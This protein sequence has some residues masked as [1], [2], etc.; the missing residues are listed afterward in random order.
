[1]KFAICNEVF[2]GWTID[3]SIKF[4]AET[5][6]D[7]IEVAPFGVRV[8]IIE[9]GVTKS[10]IFGKNTDLPNETGAYRFQYEAMMQLYAAGYVHA[11]DA[12]EVAKVILGAIEADQPRTRLN[13]GKTD[14]AGRFR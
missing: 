6:Y 14:R 10:S 12:I 7:A 9:P 11:T 3:D 4:V 2:E 5:G 8:A 13:D 1:M